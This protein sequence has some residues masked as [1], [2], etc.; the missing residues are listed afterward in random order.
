MIAFIEF[1]WC[2]LGIGL[3]FQN[4]WG[5]WLTGVPF[6][7]ILS[8]SRILTTCKECPGKRQSW[9]QALL[10]SLRTSQVAWRVP[11]L[12]RK[13]TFQKTSVAILQSIL[14]YSDLFW[15]I[16]AII[17]YLILFV[18]SRVWDL[19]PTS[20]DILRFPMVPTMVPHGSPWFPMVPSFQQVIPGHE[21]CLFSPS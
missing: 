18:S 21:P 6:C 7:P 2:R 13:V 15:H 20:S 5:E 10:L 11:N 17:G 14:I 3:R 16:L 1:L 4:V 12:K 8:Q 19:A 9:A